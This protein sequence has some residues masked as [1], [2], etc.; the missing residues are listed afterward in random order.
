MIFLHRSQV[1]RL[2]LLLLQ[3]PT[4]LMLPLT[5]K[6]TPVTADA[7]AVEGT[8]VLTLTALLDIST[9]INSGVEFAEV[10]AVVDI[11]AG[12]AFSAVLTLNSPL[13]PVLEVDKLAKNKKEEKENK[14]EE[15]EEEALASAVLSGKVVSSE[16][17]NR[18]SLGELREEISRVIERIGQ[19]YVSKYPFP[20]G[21]QQPSH[22]SS[23]GGV[24]EGAALATADERKAEF[25]QFLAA[26]GIFHELKAGLQPRVQSIIRHR[27]GARGRALGRGSEALGSV[28]LNVGDETKQQQHLLPPTV[29]NESVDAILSE[30]YVFLLKECSVVL[31]SMFSSTVIDRDEEEVEA[32]AYVDD[33]EETPAQ[34][35][36]KL[37]NQ[38]EDAFSSGLFDKAETLHLERIQLISHNAALGS[39]PQTM[40]DAYFFL[41]ES[42][43][44]QAAHHLANG[45][46][47]DPMEHE[48]YLEKVQSLVSRAREALSSSYQLRRYD[49]WRVGLLLGA[50]LVEAEQFDQAEAVLLEVIGTQLTAR[51]SSS[52]REFSLQSFSA[53]D[54]YESDALCPI[55][56]M[57]YSVLAALF[58]L[59]GF[60]L[61]ARK[62]LL[63]ANR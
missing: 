14:K 42:L 8:A 50:V 28:D 33:E 29:T 51:K 54:G 61:R 2:V 49:S 56:P 3:S 10:K 35:I 38:A 23:S 31:N 47:V 16:D 57:C 6:K 18:D 53:F 60:P 9:I 1:R 40:H 27:C 21:Q 24:G 44:Q 5:I 59:Q 48:L 41:G 46:L 39:D 19:E 4:K 52:T 17:G 45:H 26:S 11:E 13:L 36:A 25:L 37:L 22:S 15:K 30:L 12:T 55:D 63:L 7:G 32:S 62:A 43:L 58:A 34:S 20:V